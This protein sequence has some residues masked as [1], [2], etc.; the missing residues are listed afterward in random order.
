MHD[1]NQSLVLF[2]THYFELTE[3]PQQA[4]R[5]FNSHVAVVE[6][7]KRVVFLHELRE[8]PASSSYGVHVAELAG[9]PRSVVRSPLALTSNAPRLLY[10]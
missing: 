9:I 3:L 8:G 2:A 6:D 10:T 1:K 5:A 7:G 4:E